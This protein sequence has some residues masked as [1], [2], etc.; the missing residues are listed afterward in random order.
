MGKTDDSNKTYEGK[1][2]L[3]LEMYYEH[4]EPNLTIYSEPKDNRKLDDLE[5]KNKAYEVQLKEQSEKIDK[6]MEFRDEMI[7]SLTKQSKK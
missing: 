3:D 7:N 6:L 4:I 1:D 2:R 5:I